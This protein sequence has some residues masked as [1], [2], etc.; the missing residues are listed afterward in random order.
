MS[1]EKSSLTGAEEA[2]IDVLDKMVVG[3]RRATRSGEEPLA[4]HHTMLMATP[5]G[6]SLACMKEHSI[7]HIH[8]DDGIATMCIGHE[9]TRSK[10][11]SEYFTRTRTKTKTKMSQTGWH[12]TRK[13]IV[14]VQTEG[15]RLSILYE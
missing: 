1:A 5:Q 10:A 7:D 15:N 12:R 3:G 14:R 11:G 6:R 4:D 9:V 8:H 2:D 13:I